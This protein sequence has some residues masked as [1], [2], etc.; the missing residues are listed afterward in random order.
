MVYSVL[1]LLAR[2]RGMAG[3]TARR[4][5]EGFEFLYIVI[6]EFEGGRVEVVVQE[7]S[8]WQVEVIKSLNFTS[9][10]VLSPVQ[11]LVP[12]QPN[13]APIS[14]GWGIGVLEIRSR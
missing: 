9:R 6:V 13:S 7:L 4:L 11:L 1:E 3:M 14:V 8:P 10:Q 5:L 12:I 2:R